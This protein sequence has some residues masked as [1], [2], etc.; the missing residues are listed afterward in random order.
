VNS[1][2]KYG[3]TLLLEILAWLLSVLMVA[4]QSPHGERGAITVASSDTPEQVL[5]G[6]ML[7]LTLHE[8]GFEV[9]DRT[10]LGDQW[11]VRAALEAGSIDVCWQYT[12]E[13]WMGYLGHDLPVSNPENAFHRVHDADAL[14][15]ITWLA[16]AP[17]E[18]KMVVLMLRER[19]ETL[20][21]VSLSDLASYMQTANPDVRICTP[22]DI[23]RSPQGVSGLDRVY[24][25]DFRLHNVRLVDLQRGYD[26]LV[27]GDCD[28]ALG[29]LA[30]AEVQVPGS[31][32]FVAL[33]DDRGFFQ[34][35]NLA[36][37]VRTAALQEYA[38]LEPRLNRLSSLLTHQAM[39]ELDRQV[40]NKRANPEAVARRFLKRKGVLK[41]WDPFPLPTSTP[42]W[43]GQDNKQ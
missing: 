7:A 13:T 24:R 36:P 5:L 40:A 6:K 30:D 8:A 11:I 41:R 4:C 20:E 12:G 33:A 35:S 42:D 1:L 19:A 3:P 31:G 32:Q 28:C 15:G 14:N 27:H 34:A 37:V 23:Y 38:D 29:Y 21:L 17:Y 18:R 9:D 22:E 25:F 43:L 39:V 10:S 26:G 2:R 16:M